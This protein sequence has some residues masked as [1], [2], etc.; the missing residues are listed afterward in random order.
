[1]E[2]R[3]QMRAQGS[4]EPRRGHT[5]ERAHGAQMRAHGERAP[6]PEPRCGAQGGLEPRRGHTGE[7]A[8]R[9]QMRAHR[10]ERTRSPEPRPSGRVYRLP[11]FSASGTLS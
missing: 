3:A 5:G 7:R 11:L 1:M 10:G 9:A 4:L 6:G 8:H 2:P